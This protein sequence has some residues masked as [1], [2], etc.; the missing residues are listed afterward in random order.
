VI[1]KDKADNGKHTAQSAAFALIFGALATALG[2]LVGRHTFDVPTFLAVSV[3]AYMLADKRGWL[4]D[5]GARSEDRR[6][7]GQA[8]VAYAVLSVLYIVATDDHRMPLL[9][10]LYLPVVLAV[11]CYPFR[12]GLA[13]SLGTAAL[14]VIA[15]QPAT[16][17]DHPWK[18]MCAVL[19]FPTVA[20]FVRSLVERLEERFRVLSDRTHELSSLLDLSQMM[21]FAPDLDT[22][23]NL[24]LLNVQRLTGSQVCAVY[25]KNDD[26]LDLRAVSG[27]RHGNGLVGSLA[28]ADAR[29]GHWEI[30]TAAR[31]DG[32]A[33]AFYVS[34]AEVRRHSPPPSRLL[35]L[36]PRAGSF[37]CVPLT[38]IDGLLGLL[39]VGYD[40]TNG[41][42]ADA[43]R[44][45]ENLAGRVAFSLHRSVSEQDY[46]SLA[47]SDAMTGLDNF[48]QFE[49]D[50]SQ[51]M[52]RATRYG[53]Q[54]SV[55]L[56]DIDHFKGFNDSLGHQAGDA[57]LAQL[58]TVLRNSLRSLDK[59]A[60]YG[61]EEFVVVCPETGCDEAKLIAE[62]IR[63][64]VEQTAFAL[65]GQTGDPGDAPAGL[66]TAHVT[67]SVG[68]AT[69]PEN[70]AS[71]RDLVKHA[72]QALY[73]A[74]DSGRN[75]V[76][77]Y[78]AVRV[79]ERQEVAA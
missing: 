73:A 26:V 3:S 61:G 31:A 36:D 59:P 50:L 35:D 64:N 63:H 13:V 4:T 47:Y 40:Q 5:A 32:V 15:G 18:A 19:S 79:L 44:R 27:P 70:A 6:K 67:V 62:R 42:D 60:R 71:A 30:E 46:R 1:L 33:T 24:V 51:E 54:L 66:R 48:R 74:K 17:A 39:Y 10:A 69:Y 2:V 12:V 68:Y 75:T 57:L 25:L 45:L 52:S 16:L 7:S 56:F 55:I 8:T 53:R 72:D 58:A 37:A 77:G 43:I 14:F 78:D 41:L 29:G 49:E 20:V 65:L 22:T 34:E 28:V 23:L 38:T 21:D 9:S 11:I 76:R